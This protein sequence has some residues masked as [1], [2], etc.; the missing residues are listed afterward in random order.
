MKGILSIVLRNCALPEEGSVRPET[1]NS[2][3]V[4]KYCCDLNEVCAFVGL[5]C[6]KNILLQCATQCRKQLSSSPEC[7][8]ALGNCQRL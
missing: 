3:C 8:S 4:L 1:F 7:Y 5:Q 2:L 6:N